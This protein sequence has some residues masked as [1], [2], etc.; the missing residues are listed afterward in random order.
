MGTVYPLHVIHEP[1]SDKLPSASA[2][3]LCL[4][5]EKLDPSGKFRFHLLQYPGCGKQGGCMAVVAAGMADSLHGGGIV[6][7]SKIL[8]GKG[9]N[10]G[11]Q[12]DT[13]SVFRGGSFFPVYPSVHPGLSDPF[14][15]N[16]E[17]VQLTLYQ[18]CGFEFFK[19]QLRMHMEPASLFNDII[20]FL[21]YVILY[22]L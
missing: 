14:M 3:L 5:E 21:K 16:A 12:G 8:H 19:A 7:F 10:V 18:G 4:L 9:I 2:D 11:S 22:H 17:A 20:L 13:P 15:G 6:I 1:C